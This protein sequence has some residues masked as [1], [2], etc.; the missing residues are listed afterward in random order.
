MLEIIGQVLLVLIPAL[1]GWFSGVYFR[2]PNMEKKLAQAEKERTEADGMRFETYKEIMEMQAEMYKKSL[3]DIKA[4]ISETAK[5]DAQLAEMAE[6]L[7]VEKEERLKLQEAYGE[8]KLKCEAF[9]TWRCYVG[10]CHLR[11]P[12][13]QIDLTK[14]DP[15]SDN[16]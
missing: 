16:N 6:K 3:T 15:P 14:I 5:K 4:V 8:L 9:K 10:D 2:K 7:I 11:Q 12:K 13:S 1:A